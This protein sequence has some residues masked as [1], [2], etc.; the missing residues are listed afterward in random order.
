MVLSLVVLLKV[1]AF[2]HH[3]HLL[4]LLHRHQKSQSHN[5]RQC[6]R[7]R[8]SQC[9]LWHVVYQSGLIVQVPEIVG[10]HLHAVLAFNVWSH[11]GNALEQNDVNL[12]EGTFRKRKTPQT[13]KR[14]PSHLEVVYVHGFDAVRKENG[15]NG[16]APD[17]LAHTV[18]RQ[19]SYAEGLPYATLEVTDVNGVESVLLD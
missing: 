13:R 16:T 17:T 10:A 19:V 6:Q 8:Q 3:H 4:L 12:Y 2:Y 11:V 5:L 1:A 18:A 9:H 15:E 7:N 14:T